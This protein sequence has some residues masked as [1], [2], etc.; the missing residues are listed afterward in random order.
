MIEKCV[1][2]YINFNQKFLTLGHQLKLY[3]NCTYALQAI[4]YGVGFL[5]PGQTW[6]VWCL[7]QS[8]LPSQLMHLWTGGCNAS[9]MEVTKTSISGSYLWHCEGYFVKKVG[10]EDKFLKFNVYLKLVYLKLV[11][12]SMPICIVHV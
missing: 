12:K 6:A 2:M 11:T 7:S 9:Q 8:N 5:W 10:Y 4:F 1:Y 3:F